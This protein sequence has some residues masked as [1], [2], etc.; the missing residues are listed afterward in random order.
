MN[1]DF[2]MAVELKDRII[3]SAIRWWTGEALMDED[4]GFGGDDD[5]LGEDDDEDGEE[6]Y[7]SEE[8]EEWTP[9]TGEGGQDAPAPECKQQ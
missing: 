3:P 2:A 5:E 7:N 8:D 4:D 6:E 9:A 1:V